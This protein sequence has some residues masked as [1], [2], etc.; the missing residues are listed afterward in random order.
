MHIFHFSQSHLLPLAKLKIW[1]VSFLILDKDM[2]KTTQVEVLK[3]LGKLGHVT[4]L[5]GIQSR[6]SFLAKEK[7]LQI[8]S[9]PLRYKSYITAILYT[10]IMFFLLPLICVFS[11]PKIIVVEPREPTFLSTF[12][13][14]GFPKAA[15]PKIVLDIR[16]VPVGQG[17]VESS[18]FVIALEMAKKTFDGITIITNMMKQEICEKFGL[19]PN[20]VGVWTSGASTELF[21]P[22]RFDKRKLRKSLNLDEKFVVFYHGVLGVGKGEGRGIAECIKSL[23]LLKNSYPNIALF[24]LGDGGSFPRLEMLS[25][26]AGVQEMVIMHNRVDYNEV[27]KYIAISDVAI[28]PLPN[29]Q[30]WRNQ[31][32]LKLLEY[33]SMERVVVA[34]DIPANRNIM[35]ESKCAIYVSSVEPTEIAKGI[36][37]AYNNRERLEDWGKEGRTIILKEYEW[38]KVAKD[39]EKYLLNLN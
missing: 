34:T 3:N 15:R 35:K 8:V 10:T 27:P 33:L 5:Y 29:L 36:I 24:I 32:A 39:F 28:V 17:I 13:I 31:C 23:Q 16:S 37:Q 26:E 30:K 20:K 11:K 9:I 21:D 1:W 14:I 38:R 7:N 12:S 6:H 18:L 22:K 2:H 25:R 19:N 4:S